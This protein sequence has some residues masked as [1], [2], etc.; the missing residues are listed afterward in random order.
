MIVSSASKGTL[1]FSFQRNKGIASAEE[2]GN[3]SKCWTKTRITGSGRI[4]ATSSSRVRTRSQAF[5][6]ADLTTNEFKRLVSTAE[7]IIAP[8]G[9]DSM[10]NSS[11]DPVR[12]QRATAR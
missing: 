6:I 9:N 4:K 1:F 11:S 12:F 8:G 10:A 2:R 5:A 3:A 7:G